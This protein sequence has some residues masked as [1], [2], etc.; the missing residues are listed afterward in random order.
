MTVIQT[1]GLSKRY[2]DKWAVD[3]L[4]LQVEQGDIY[5]FIG[6]NGA[7]KSTTLKLLCGLIRPTQGEDIRQAHSG[8]SGPS[9]GGGT[10]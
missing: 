9:P 7:G 5:G 10:H 1:S 2:K 4:D 6:R 8:R 3:H